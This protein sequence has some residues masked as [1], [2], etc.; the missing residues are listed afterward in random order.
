MELAQIP[1]KQRSW[2]DLQIHPS[3]LEKVLG[4][5]GLKS[6]DVSE[7][8]SAM[9]L[10]RTL[11]ES[12]RNAG[13]SQSVIS[14]LKTPNRPIPNDFS[15]R[16]MLAVGNQALKNLNEEAIGDFLTE[17]LWLALEAK[18][19]RWKKFPI[20]P[21][22]ID[23]AESDPDLPE[24]PG[25]L[26]LENSQEFAQMIRLG[27]GLSRIYPENIPN[28]EFLL[29]QGIDQIQ[30]SETL[31]KAR[32]PVQMLFN[33]ELAWTHSDYF[34]YLMSNLK[35]CI[36]GNKRRNLSPSDKLELDQK[37]QNDR[38]QISLEMSR[39][40]STPISAN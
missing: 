13:F 4:A 32:D 30:L 5:V 8:Q 11:A 36:Y 17:Y 14:Q 25:G 15:S 16:Q 39:W 6:V 33:S 19:I 40:N 31:L 1:L 21:I 10:P 23:F 29:S 27:R 35:M 26:G 18:G 22:F 38:D 28:L 9:Y 7:L 12:L 24:I 37:F 2:R 20:E 34:K 3:H